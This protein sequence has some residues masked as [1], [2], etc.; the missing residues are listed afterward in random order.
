MVLFVLI[1]NKGRTDLK[2]TVSGPRAITDNG[3]T[4]NE[5]TVSCSIIGRERGDVQLYRIYSSDRRELIE[6]VTGNSSLRTYT[7]SNLTCLDIGLY[8]WVIVTRSLS[9]DSPEVVSKEDFHLPVDGKES[10]F[11]CGPIV[12]SDHVDQGILG[13]PAI[14]GVT[15]KAYPRVYDGTWTTGRS[16]NIS[17]DRFRDYSTLTR[18]FD[19]DPYTANFYLI[20]HNVTEKDFTDYVLHVAA[21]DG[22]V[23]EVRKQLLKYTG[24]QEVRQMDVRCSAVLA[25]GWGVSA[26]LFLALIFIGLAYAIQTRVR[27]RTGHLNLKETE[28]LS[29]KDGKHTALDD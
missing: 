11:K 18:R 24:A 26:A 20:L 29:A 15:V 14:F 9:E 21:S 5:I 27:N 28:L 16:G 2:T 7:F 22:H 3:V 23:T 17:L 12:I 8:E 10:N 25:L 6:G 19:L 13:Y 4:R 1:A